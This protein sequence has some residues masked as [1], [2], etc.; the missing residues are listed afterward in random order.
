MVPSC[1]FGS[2]P[3][4]LL[5]SALVQKTRTIKNLST[6]QVV[7]S[8][9]GIKC[10][11]SGGSV[12]SAVHTL[13]VY[14]LR[15]SIAASAPFA[16]SPLR[17]E[18]EVK[19]DSLDGK[20]MKK[21]G[22]GVTGLSLQSDH[23]RAIVHRTWGLLRKAKEDDLDC[24]DYGPRFAFRSVMKFP[25]T[26]QKLLF[27]AWYYSTALLLV[28]VPPARM[29]ARHYYKPGS[30]LSAE[31]R[32]GNFFEFRATAVADKAEVEGAEAE[33]WSTNRYT[34]ATMRFS[35]DI[36]DF[37]ALSLAEAAIV[38]TQDTG[39][40]IAGKVRGVVTPSML[41]EPFM[42]RLFEAGLQTN[43]ETCH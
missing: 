25:N 18:M 20:A 41:G 17:P 38:L 27:A 32:Q 31:K 39:Y 23:D 15:K 8:I 34:I 35:G 22:F 42:E 28:V 11:A 24:H 7:V 4:D 6:G 30:G 36:Y 2:A 19:V 16:L 5:T 29:V 26:L 13:A 14:G 3:A 33:D 1:G 10:H 40:T 12:Q 21:L 43:F 37:T 9:Q